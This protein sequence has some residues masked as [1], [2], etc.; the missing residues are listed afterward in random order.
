MSE[1]LFQTIPCVACG[2]N[3][4]A[5][6]S[7]CSK[8]REFQSKWRN[9]L[10]F[11]A[12]IAGLIVLISSGLAFSFGALKFARDYFRP[13]DLIVSE[14]NTFGKITLMNMAE[15]SAWVK[16]LRIRSDNPQHDLKW[17]LGYVLKPRQLYAVNMIELSKTQFQGLS[18]Q[19]FGS[20]QGIYARKLSPETAAEVLR[21]M[22]RNKYVPVFLHRDG[23]EYRQVRDYLNDQVTVF[24]CNAELSYVFVESETQRIGRI[25]CVGVVKERTDFRIDAPTPD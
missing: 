20:A 3:I 9:E 6:A 12:G 8:C 4:S 15:Q 5:N 23:A 7:V 16:G 24:D 22:H 19:I 13:P 11:W 21:S 25:P 17:D 18:R 2:E 10:K 14:I 1:I